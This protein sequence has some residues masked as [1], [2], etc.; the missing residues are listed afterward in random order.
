[1]K[2]RNNKL[3]KWVTPAS[4]I[5]TAAT[6]ATPTLAQ[7]VSEASGTDHAVLE[8]VFVTAQRRTENSQDVPM[9]VMAL[10]MEALEKMGFHTMEDIADKVPSL[11]IQPDFETAS[12]LKVYIR[13]VGQ[14]KP[15]NFE[16]DNGV[17][18]YLDDIYVGHGNGLASEMMDVERIEVLSGPQG[19]LY[20][21]NTIGGAVKFISEKPTGELGFKQK[22]DV[23]NFGLFRSVSTLDLNDIGNVSS[24]FT[25]LKSEKDGWVDN[26]GEAGNPGDRD[27]TGF[28]AALRWAPSQDWLID[29]AFDTLQQD[30]ISNYQ[31]HGYPKFATSLENLQEFPD[32]EDDTWRPIDVNVK[33]DFESSSHSLTAAWDINDGMVLKSITGYRE[34]ESNSL[35]DGAESYNVSTL[36]AKDADQDQISQE[37]LLSGS[38]SDASI[39]YHVGLYYFKEEVV[40][41]ESE[42]ESNYGIALA[43]DTALGLGE[44]IVAP[45]L[46]DLK[47]FNTYDIENES[48]AV[49]AQITW[50]P[51]ILDNKLT[52][53]LGARY[54]EDDRS[55]KWNKP[56][57]AGGDFEV[58]DADSV[59][60]SSTDPTFTVDYAWTDDIHTYFRY[61]QGY[62]SGGFDTGSERLQAFDPEELESFEIG[63]KSKLLDDRLLLNVAIFTMDYEDIQVQF[64]DPGLDADEPPA[65]VTV[66]AA[67]A[68]TEGAELELKFL[69][70]RGLMLSAAFAYLDSETSVTNPFSGVTE[71]RLL[72]NTPEWK[73]NLA[74]EYA[75]NPSSIGTFTAIVS[76]DYRDE[77]LAAGSS[78]AED[79]KP[80]YGL[81]GARLSLT[82][83]PVPVGNLNVALWGRNLTDEEYEVYHNFGSVIYGEPQSYGLSLVY[84]F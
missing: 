25:F 29:Y 23:G 63:F 79:L 37:F 43:I 20:G 38:N 40:Q 69:P 59:S 71:D 72:F 80:D 1:M 31:Q 51:A 5:L 16:R 54:T 83:I 4:V 84:D 36:V 77:E 13:G 8:E 27:A 46:S 39:Q 18:I 64:F 30:S 42:L 9:S 17:G 57:N 60:S 58:D 15:A 73:Y 65:K 44:P 34:F 81:L 49:Y 28:R 74:A 24:R 56:S 55:L 53:D 33:D 61:A 70:V 10:S 66:N 41:H 48:Q 78:D 14:E 68:T 76:Y 2:M 7:A 82:E 32:R 62:R 22:L 67:E 19:T 45:A 12:A 47:P 21:R 50:T 6:F 35:H 26:K 75:F 11:S 52:F 3:Q